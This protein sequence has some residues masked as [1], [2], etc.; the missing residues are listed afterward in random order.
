MEGG[1][2]RRGACATILGFPGVA[3]AVASAH[4]PQRG[5]DFPSALAFCIGA[6]APL[7][8]LATTWIYYV[9]EWAFMWLDIGGWAFDGMETVNRV[10]VEL[11]AEDSDR[12]L[13]ARAYERSWIVPVPLPTT[14]SVDTPRAKGTA[15]IVLQMTGEDRPFGWSASGAVA[16]ARAAMGRGLRPFLVLVEGITKRLSADEVEARPRPGKPSEP[17][18]SR[19]RPQRIPPRR[20]RSPRSGPGRRG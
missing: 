16:A 13:L 1:I 2:N 18:G 8:P 7:N 12:G 5:A 11:I 14:I 10:C 15:L 6:A 9:S 4:L 3:V 20:A 17:L 19:R